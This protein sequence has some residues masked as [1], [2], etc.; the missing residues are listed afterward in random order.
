ME[1]NKVIKKVENNRFVEFCGNRK[2]YRG[3]RLCLDHKYLNNGIKR[4]HLKILTVNKIVGKM[5]S[6]KFYISLGAT[7]GFLHLELHVVEVKISIC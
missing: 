7:S 5:K 2:V 3:V 6:A 4:E 1:K